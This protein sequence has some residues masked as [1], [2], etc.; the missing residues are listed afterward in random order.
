GGRAFLPPRCRAFSIPSSPPSHRARARVLASP[1]PLTLRVSTAA[2]WKAP[3]APAA[4]PSSNSGSQRDADRIHGAPHPDRARRERRE[5]AAAL[6]LWSLRASDHAG[7]GG[8][9]RDRGARAHPLRSRGALCE[10]LRAC[11]RDRAAGGRGLGPPAEGG[12]GA[13]RAG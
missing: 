9:P 13:A 5:R 6:P 8:G 1:C 4:G 12:G 2:P 3:T 10:S 7:S 11:P